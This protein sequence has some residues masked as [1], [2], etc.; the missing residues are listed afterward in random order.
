H[1]LKGN[2]SMRKSTAA[3]GL[4]A[5]ATLALTGCGVSAATTGD[6]S[7]WPEEI[8]ISLVPSTE[9]ADLAEALDPLTS[10]LSDELGI[11]VKGVVADNYAATVEA[12]G[13]D[14]AQ[15]IITDAGSLYHAINQYDAELILR[16]VR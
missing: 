16:D 6:A 11:T 10:Y 8:T 4:L 7:T 3:A 13:A 2:P 5:A 9:N 1:H 15:V 14:Q 12:L